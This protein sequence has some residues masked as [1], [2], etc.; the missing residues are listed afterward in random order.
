MKL[1]AVALL[2]VGI[3]AG[4]GCAKPKP[5]QR[6]HLGTIHV[7]YAL[8]DAMGN[9]GPCSADY[10]FTDTSA[11]GVLFQAPA[12]STGAVGYIPYIGGERHGISGCDLAASCWSGR[13]LNRSEY[14]CSMDGGKT[15]FPARVEADR[16]S[17]YATDAKK[18]P[19]VKP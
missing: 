18:F 7:C 12:A 6:A 3:G 19:Q 5:T 8:V 15:W 16:I 1:A 4:M 13:T 2:L 10:S 14:A 11:K 17:C 9:E